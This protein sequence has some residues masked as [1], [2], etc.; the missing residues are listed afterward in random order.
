MIDCPQFQFVAVK[1]V[2]FSVLCPPQVASSFENAMAITLLPGKAVG[3]F[4]I[5]ASM[6][7]CIDLLL[8]STLSASWSSVG[9]H[10]SKPFRGF[11]LACCRYPCILGVPFVPNRFDRA[12]KRFKASSTALNT[13]KVRRWLM[14]SLFEWKKPASRCVSCFFAATACRHLHSLSEITLL[15][16]IVVKF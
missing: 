15:Y 6:N 14:T 10:V 5:G 3:P 9:L 13:I 12:I 11:L 7:T 1:S 16:G 2:R 8:V 4:I